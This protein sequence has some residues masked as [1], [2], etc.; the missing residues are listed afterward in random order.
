MLIHLR[1]TMLGLM[2]PSSFAPAEML[3]RSEATM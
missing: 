2:V 3:Y 1:T